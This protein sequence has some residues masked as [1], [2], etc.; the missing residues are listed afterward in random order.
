M[1]HGATKFLIGTY[2]V[3]WRSST[4]AKELKILYS[5]IRSKIRYLSQYFIR[6]ILLDTVYVKFS[7]ENNTWNSSFRTL[8]IVW[9][10]QRPI[11]KLRIQLERDNETS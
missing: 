1:L 6:S 7:V 11:S 3:A 5:K 10:A 9:Y 2:F 4:P 8:F